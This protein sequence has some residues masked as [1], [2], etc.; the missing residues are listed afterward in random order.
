MT[1]SSAVLWEAPDGD[2][3]ARRAALRSM[4]AASAGKRDEWLAAFSA[5]AH[6]ED[7]VGP[8]MLDP[9]GEGHRGHAG[10][11]KFWDDFVGPVQGIRFHV[12][13]SFANGPCCANIATLTM[14]LGHGATMLVDCVIVYTVDEEGLITSL[15]AHWEPERAMA[16]LSG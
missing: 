2:H 5:D 11:A 14:T 8:S 9:E 7:P 12:K 16:T 4:T 13:D 3:P 10:I 15:R 6:V 1:S